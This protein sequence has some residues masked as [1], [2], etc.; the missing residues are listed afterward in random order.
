MLLKCAHAMESAEVM[1]E[2]GLVP[3]EYPFIVGETYE[4]VEILECSG[5]VMARRPGETKWPQPGDP[6]FNWHLDDVFEVPDAPIEIVSCGCACIEVA[7]YYGVKVEGPADVKRLS[8]LEDELELIEEG[9]GFDTWWQRAKA[10][11]PEDVAR[12]WYEIDTQ[13]KHVPEAWIHDDFH[14]TVEWQPFFTVAFGYDY[15]FRNEISAKMANDLIRNFL[16]ALRLEKTGP[17]D[18][19]YFEYWTSYKERRIP[20]RVRGESE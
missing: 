1:T 14:P 6:M 20:V 7:G 5:H 2:Q 11:V 13:W 4:V 17:A 8:V 3:C 10:D 15:L 12:V 16:A 9:E 18:H 19:L